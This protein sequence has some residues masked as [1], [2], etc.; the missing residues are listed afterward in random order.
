MILREP[1][2]RA[3]HNDWRIPFADLML[4]FSDGEFVSIC[5]Q[6]VG[7]AFT[8]SVVKAIDACAQVQS[9]PE[10]SCIWFSINAIDG[11]ERHL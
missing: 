8:S 9:L 3:T 5:H 2:D 11:P 10:R 4:S 6:P 1:D 7:G